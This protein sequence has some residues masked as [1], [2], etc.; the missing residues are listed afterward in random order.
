[1]RLT[2][3][4]EFA[5]SERPGNEI[6]LSRCEA[7]ARKLYPLGERLDD[8]P[9]LGR[10]PCLP[11]MRPVIGPAASPRPVVQLRP[12]P[13]RPHPGPGQ[14]PPAG[15]AATGPFTDPAPTARRFD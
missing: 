12:R 2:T 8:K 9:W 1:V 6:Q 5:A 14:R 4:I 3:G 13:P 10:R 11:D 7:L 15:R